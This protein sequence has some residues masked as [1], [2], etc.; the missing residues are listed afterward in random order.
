MDRTN[1]GVDVDQA[2]IMDGEGDIVLVKY[3]ENVTQA[4]YNRITCTMGALDWIYKDYGS[5]VK[6]YIG[7][8]NTAPRRES[9]KTEIQKRI[10]RDPRLFD[11]DVTIVAYTPKYIGLKITGKLD[12]SHENFEEYLIFGEEDGYKSYLLHRVEGY[13]DTFIR[14][15]AE[16]YAALPGDRLVVHAHV[17]SKQ[18]NDLVPIG[19]VNLRVGNYGIGQA[20][21]IQQSWGLEPGTV[22][23]AF[24]VPRFFGYGL[25]YLEFRYSGAPGYNPCTKEVPLYV[26]PYMPTKTKHLHK[27]GTNYTDRNDRLYMD[28]YELGKY[29]SQKYWTKTPDQLE[30]DGLPET[31]G[32][33]GVEDWNGIPVGYGDKRSNAH[34]KVKLTMIKKISDKVRTTIRMKE[35]DESFTLKQPYLIEDCV[36]TDEYK[37]PVIS[38][39]VNIYLDVGSRV[40]K[41]SSD[42]STLSFTAPSLEQGV[43]YQLQDHNGNLVDNIMIDESNDE[44]TTLVSVNEQGTDVIVID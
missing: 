9:L 24:N 44:E 26:V 29:G 2:W 33:V 35:D 27:L 10:N 30:K 11:A 40:I 28:V 14:S 42:P 16:G 8:P 3:E 39:K 6:E 23:I 31:R 41:A 34:G 5:Y 7:K 19:K 36:V 25:H 21:E 4:V 12:G 37:R 43:V 20:V 38:G 17:Y 1:L 32:V 22:T 15:R 13:D 18:T